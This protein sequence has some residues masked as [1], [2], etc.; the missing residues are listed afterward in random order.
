MSCNLSTVANQDAEKVT[1]C[2][3]LYAGRSPRS[4]PSIRVSFP[5][6]RAVS[7]VRSFYPG[8]PGKSNFRKKCFFPSDIVPR[9]EHACTCV[10]DTPGR[11]LSTSHV[12]RLMHL[13]LCAVTWGCATFGPRT[14]TTSRASAAAAAML[15]SHS[16]RQGYCPCTCTAAARA[17]DTQVCGNREGGQFSHRK[18]RNRGGGY[19]ETTGKYICPPDLATH[20]KGFAAHETLHA[21]GLSLAFIHATC[22]AGSTSCIVWFCRLVSPL[23]KIALV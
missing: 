12:C 7:R 23:P 3:P 2:V 6:C 18:Q 20:P 1:A 22:R 21:L 14:T 16:C 10:K 17:R 9:V 4:F 8:A 11:V 19:D 5:E 15:C 13:A